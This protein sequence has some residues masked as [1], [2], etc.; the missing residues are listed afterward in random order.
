MVPLPD[1]A[2]PSIRNMSW[3]E[4]KLGIMDARIR[5]ARPEDTEELVRLVAAFRAELARL[6]GEERT[7]DPNAA[8]EEF[9]E[10][11]ERGYPIY[12]AELEGEPVGY[13]VCRVE[14]DVVWAEQLYV[15]P[16]LRRRGIGSALYAEAERICRELGGDTVY[17][18][19]HPNNDAIIAFLAAR[20]YTVLNLIELRRP[21]PGER[22]KRRIRVGAHEFDY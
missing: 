18:W 10:F 19:V 4:Y 1:F 17:N 7:P 11:Q 12:V 15:V 20:G 3:A 22:P 13:L 9:H 5:E 21:L 2:A 14:D 6:H 16:A 8:R